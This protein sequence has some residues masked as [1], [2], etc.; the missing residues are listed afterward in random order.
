MADVGGRRSE[1]GAGPSL[2]GRTNERASVVLTEFETQRRPVPRN[3][4]D[5]LDTSLAFLTFARESVLKK[6]DGFDD[7]QV[8]RELVPSGTTLL[9][10][11]RHLT[12]VEL[13]WFDHHLVGDSANAPMPP[14]TFGDNRQIRLARS[15][16]FERILYAAVA[17]TLVV[18][19]CSLT[20]SAGGG[21]VERKRPFTLLRVSGT[22][23]SVL[24]RVVLL[25]AAVPL[26]TVTVIAAAIDTRIS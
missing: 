13:F 26:V 23:V 24:S 19:G 4:D 17:L 20:V 9:G 3:D 1:T 12:E 18:A 16:T 15:A 14:R 22:P 10:L 2:G 8:R 5:E 7:K 25:G 21:F 11:V 6:L